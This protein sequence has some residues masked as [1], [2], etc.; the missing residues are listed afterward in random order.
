VGMLST[1]A[2]QAKVMRHSTISYRCTVISACE[3]G[4]AWQLASSR[5]QLVGMLLSTM[6]RLAKVEWHYTI[7]YMCTLI[8]ACVKGW[9]MTMGL[10][11]TVT[12]TKLERDTISYRCTMIIVCAKGPAWQLASSQWQWVGMLSTMARHAKVE[13]H[14]TI[15]YRC[16]MISAC[17][18]GWRMAMG[19]HGISTRTKVERDT[20]S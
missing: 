8:S 10:H 18:K 6:A 14:Y 16:T 19:L 20:I 3:K 5:W 13:L 9:R 4:P 1:M 7:S 17:E 11:S 2:R 15:S 12:L